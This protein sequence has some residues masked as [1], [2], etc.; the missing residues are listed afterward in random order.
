MT[1]SS[2]SHRHVIGMWLMAGVAFVFASHDAVSKT[3]IL[4]LPV[5][6][7][8]WARYLIHTSIVTTVILRNRQRSAFHTKRPW[9]HLLR[10]VVLLADSLSFLFGLVHVPL[11][12]STALVFL[13]PAFV[14]LLSPLLFGIKAD[15]Y[16][17]ISVCVGFV[18][19]LVIINPA[20]DAFSLW[21]LF[22][23]ATAF[24][25]ALYQM[26]TQLAGETDSPSVCSFYVGIYC[27]LILSVAVP[28][29]WVSPDLTQWLMLVVLGTL[30]LC[31]HSL[32]A[33]SYA[34]AS[35]SVL[36]PL[37]YLQIVFATAYGVVLFGGYP[38]LSS[39]LGMV[40]IFLSGL[41][42]YAKRPVA[43]VLQ[44]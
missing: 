28:F 31:A 39:V 21:M 25:F 33:K 2:Q 24:F 7:V 36:A 14:T 40:L 15:R 30:G 27:T 43:V 16:Q 42:V 1:S 5:I 8:A 10:A 38:T 13:A 23:L 9:L 35:S 3:L 32:L 19:V 20:S 18:G 44:D 12:E 34:Y 22:P 41:V 26:L 37:G 17:W 6:F 4:A 29:F 11:A